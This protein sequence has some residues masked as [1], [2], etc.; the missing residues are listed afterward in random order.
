MRD[1]VCLSEFPTAEGLDWI[2]M[3]EKFL[4]QTTFIHYGDEDAL[5]IVTIWR[6]R[7]R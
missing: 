5:R 7:K 1:L 4:E 2:F 6:Y 3:P